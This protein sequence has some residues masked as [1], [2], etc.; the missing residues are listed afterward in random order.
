MSGADDTATRILEA[1]APVFA[2]EGF[3]GASTRVLAH[4]AGVNVATLAYHFRDKQGLYDAIVE[5]TYESLLAV[6]LDGDAT[7]DRAVRLRAMVTRLYR[8]ARAHCVEVRVLLRHVLDAQQLPEAA[9]ARF[10]PAA[11][12]L[13]AT[14]V[15]SLDIPFDPLPLLSLNHLLVRYALTEEADLALMGLDHDRVAAHLGDVACRLFSLD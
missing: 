4:A 10:L 12:Q 1:A 14:A 5:R 2:A 15:A 3:A 9:R 7:G 6:D 8:Y 11:L 13:A